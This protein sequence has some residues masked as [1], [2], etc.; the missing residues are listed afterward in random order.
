MNGYFAPIADPSGMQE[1]TQVAEPAGWYQPNNVQRTLPALPGI[2][3]PPGATGAW[4]YARAATQF[5][6]SP[7]ETPALSAGLTLAA[8]GRVWLPSA[9][10][11]RALCILLGAS[12]GSFVIQFYTG[13]I[14]PLPAVN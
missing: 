3:V 6:L 11:V 5:C 2:S 1:F 14:G 4:L 8:G 10:S 12:G 7:N 13:N 9:A